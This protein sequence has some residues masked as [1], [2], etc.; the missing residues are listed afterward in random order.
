DASNADFAR[1]S[2]FIAAKPAWPSMVLFRKRAEA[3]LWQERAPPA[4]VR[5][6]FG[7]SRPLSAKGRFAL[8]RAMLVEGDRAGAQAQAREAW[9]SDSFAE[10]LEAQARDLFGDLLTRADDKTRMDRRLYRA[11]DADEGLRAARRLSAVELAIAKARIAVNAKA[12]NAK[13]LL[14]AVP[15]AAQ[16]D[17]GLIFSRVQWLRR[18]DKIEEAGA[19]MLSA[20]RDLNQI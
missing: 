10:E 20:P 1:Y 15:A 17:A 4:T 2:A 13:T 18:A 5:A 16:H 7:T 11:D 14:D 6:Y 9:R 8:A 12:G 3:M 19:L